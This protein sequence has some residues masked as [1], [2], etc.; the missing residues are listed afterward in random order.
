MIDH[1]QE[2]EN[3]K[4]FYES[5]LQLKKATGNKRPTT[6]LTKAPSV[7]EIKNEIASTGRIAPISR[8][9]F[10]RHADEDMRKELTK[11]IV[12]EV[13]LDKKAELLS[14]FYQNNFP[15]SH[16][17]IIEYVE[18]AHERLRDT[19]LIAL[20]NCESKIARNYA[21]SLL[22]SETHKALALKTLL[23]NYAPQD[24]ELLLNACYALKVEYEDECD[25]HDIG[26][27][28][29]NLY[30]KDKELPKEFLLY[31]YNTTLCSCCRFTAIRELDKRQWLTTDIIEECRFDSNKNITEYINRYYP[32]K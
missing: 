14:L 8:V 16:E 15:F 10:S 2:S 29:L 19:A 27:K 6:N 31:I 22:Q 13:D 9:R 24:K 18:S 21:L 20:T 30:N 28:I 4:C 7:E 12:A 3:V 11:E 25:W 32:Q 1:S 5:Y 26:Y 23:Q 17:I